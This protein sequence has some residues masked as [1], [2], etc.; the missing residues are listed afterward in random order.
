MT[1]ALRFDVDRC[2]ARALLDPT[3]DYVVASQTP[4]DSRRPPP[5]SC[6]SSDF[7]H[8]LSEI[9]RKIASI[10]TDDEDA[11]SLRALTQNLMVIRFEFET[12][13]NYLGVSSALCL[14]SST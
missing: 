10:R 14:Y 3:P 6:P 4:S 2:L 11:A 13:K 1:N 9:S 12:S 7:D 8:N 5:S